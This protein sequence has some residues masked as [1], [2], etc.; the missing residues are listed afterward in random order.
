MSVDILILG[1]GWSSNFLMPLCK[2]R[3]IKFAATSRSGRDATIPF[4]FD[5]DSD[6]QRPYEALPDAKTVLITFPIQKSGASQRL[7]KCYASSRKNKII[8]GFIQLGA[9]SMWDVSWP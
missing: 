8:V 1:A 9:T 3:G 2:E 7:V 6:D 5:P 4:L